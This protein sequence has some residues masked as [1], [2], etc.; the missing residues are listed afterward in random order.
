M[1]SLTKNLDAIRQNNKIGHFRYTIGVTLFGMQLINYFDRVNLST[2]GP[3]MMSYF[4][5]SST[6]FGIVSSAFTWTYMIMQ[7][8]SGL[9]LDK[10]G[11][12]WVSRVSSALWAIP[13]FLTAFVSGLGPLILLRVL[14]GVVEAP[15]TPAGSKAA[16]YWFPLRE[17]GLATAL[18][19]SGTK[20]ANVIGVPVCAFLVLHY[21]W[22]SAF[23]FTAIMSVIFSLWYWI[24][25]RNPRESSHLS[26]AELKYIEQG[27][28]QEDT[29]P[30]PGINLWFVLRQRKM[31]GLMLGNFAYNY[32]TFMFLTWLPSFFVKT[33]NLNIQQ[34]G[35]MTAIPWLF[36]F[37]AEIIVG[38]WF[39]DHLIKRGLDASKVRKTTIVIGLSMGIALVGAA[40]SPSVWIAVIW[41]TIALTGVC[42][43][44]A[45]FWA[46]PSIIAPTGLVG[47]VSSTMNVS[48]MIAAIITPIITGAAVD[49]TGSFATAFIL[50]GV[51][52]I[53]GVFGILVLMG[54]IEQMHPERNDSNATISR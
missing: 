4:H 49:A 38:G 23:F 34:S 19:D 27:G 39:V 16:G 18:Y 24:I 1:S 13:T 35:F 50:I 53:L 8:P 2:A 22:Q 51:V 9:I 26:K 54:P 37:I 17:R 6:E 36:G 48:G 43:S 40:Y 44:A 33:L 5:M 46:I 14:L 28:A 21:G 29:Q 7:I 45:G 52:L 30:E 25:Y 42:V 31:W 41:F 10:I 32:A 3:S 15:N 12:K 20:F 11:V 47:V